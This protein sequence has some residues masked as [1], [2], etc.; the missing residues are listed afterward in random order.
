MEGSWLAPAPLPPPSSTSTT[1]TGATPGACD[2][3]VLGL[4]EADYSSILHNKDVLAKR[5]RFEARWEYGDLSDVLTGRLPGRTRADERILYTHM[6]MG[7]GCGFG[8]RCLPPG[9]GDRPRSTVRALPE[10]VRMT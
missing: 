4:R 7:A 9:R 10:V 1:W 2:K 6:G 8:R 3:W 5:R